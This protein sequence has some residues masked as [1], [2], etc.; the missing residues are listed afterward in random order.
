MEKPLRPRIPHKTCTWLCYALHCCG[1]FIGSCVPIGS[2]IHFFRI[3]SLS[4]VQSYNYGDVI[5][6]AIASQIISHTIVY[7]T[8]Y[9]D[10]DQR[11]HQ[12]S[13]SLAFVRGLHRGPVNSPHKWPVTRKMFP[14][15]DVIMQYLNGDYIMPKDRNQLGLCQ[16][17]RKHGEYEFKSA[18]ILGKK[19]LA[20]V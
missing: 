12:S 5:M 10:A 20:G 6:G 15:D 3:V 13:A 14:F 9:S 18:L 1:C 2:I 11:E 19:K 8:V 4:L 17:T 16:T 7:S